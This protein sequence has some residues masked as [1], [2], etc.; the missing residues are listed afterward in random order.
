MRKKAP[1]IL[2]LM[3]KELTNREME[4]I[5][6][7]LG[8]YGML[9]MSCNGRKGGLALLWRADMTVYTKTYSPNHIDVSVHTQTSPI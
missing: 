4:P 1:T 5:K 3:E 2:F 9:A 7:D 6:R 8:F